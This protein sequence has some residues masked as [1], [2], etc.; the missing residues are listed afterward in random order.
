M[1]KARDAK[2][3]MT[4]WQRFRR[5][6]T[7]DAEKTLL[8]ELLQDMYAHRWKIYQIN[9]VRGLFFGLGSVLG[10]TILL[11]LLVWLL[12]QLG[13]VVP[14]LSDFIQQVLDTLNERGK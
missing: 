10:G 5:A 12:A 13:A 14:F 6:Q 4:L 8:E 3:K 1:S 2:K 11:A 7:I 9:F